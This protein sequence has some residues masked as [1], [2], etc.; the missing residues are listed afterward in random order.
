MNQDAEL[1][2]AQWIEGF[3]DTPG[4]GGDLM[5]LKIGQL[6][7]G[8]GGSDFVCLTLLNR[9]DILSYVAQELST[10]N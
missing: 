10:E 5:M 6:I 3:D 7:V 1:L 4:G 8:R 2:W 9:K